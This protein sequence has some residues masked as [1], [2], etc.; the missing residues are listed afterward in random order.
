MSQILNDPILFST[1]SR[2]KKKSHKSVMVEYFNQ[3]CFELL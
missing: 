3:N 2:K 1:G